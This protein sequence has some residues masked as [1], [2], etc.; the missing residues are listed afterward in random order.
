MANLFSKLKQGIS[1]T[2]V[3]VFDRISSAV[4]SKRKIDDELLEEIEEILISGDVGV[5]T[6]LELIERVKKRVKKEKY[7]DSEDLI[8]LL[9]EEIVKMFPEGQFSEEQLE[10]KPY[11]M[12]VVGVNGTGKTTSIAKIANRFQQQGKK[13]LLAAADTFRAAAIEQLQVWADRLGVDMIKH[14]S[15][16]DPAAVVFDALQAARAREADVLIIDT[17]GRLHTKVNLMEELKKIRRVIQKGMPDAPHL[18]LLV[19]DAT[20]GQNALSQA[21]QFVES[22]AVDGIVLTKLDGTAKGGSIIGISHQLGLPVYYVGVGEK[23]DDLQPFDPQLYAEG[24][25]ESNASE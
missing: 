5:E 19:L 14:H 20:T 9:R 6:S 8:M 24:L 10:A 23:M 11:V 4:K 12:L 3:Q 22:V 15:G 1:K 13:V 16:S 7:E 25:F 18:T 21:R 2:K 17:A